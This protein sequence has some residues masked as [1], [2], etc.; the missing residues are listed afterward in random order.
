MSKHNLKKQANKKKPNSLVF[1][2]LEKFY[3]LVFV[4]SFLVLFSYFFFSLGVPDSVSL[5]QQ[6]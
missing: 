4:C 5:I 2:A 3:L 6:Q 1:H